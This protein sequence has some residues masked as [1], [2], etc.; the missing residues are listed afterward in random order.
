M[1]LASAIETKYGVARI[2]GTIIINIGDPINYGEF[3]NMGVDE[4][5]SRVELKIKYLSGENHEYK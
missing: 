2:R 1:C 3:K 4:L 5:L